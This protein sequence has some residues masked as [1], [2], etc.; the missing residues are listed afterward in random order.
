M[1]TASLSAMAG[2][3]CPECGNA[4]V[5]RKDGCEFCTNCGHVGQC[6]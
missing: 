1:A 6:G 2:K 5:I 3:V 4:S